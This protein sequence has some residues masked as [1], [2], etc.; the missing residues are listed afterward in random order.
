MKWSKNT[1]YALCLYM[2]VRL[3]HNRPKTLL[4]V[5]ISMFHFIIFLVP[6]HFVKTRPL[7][8][9]IATVLTLFCLTYLYPAFKYDQLKIEILQELQEFR[10]AYYLPILALIIIKVVCSMSRRFPANRLE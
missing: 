3:K 5:S 1:R 8:N 9:G 6:A 10:L 7:W 2:S 4:T